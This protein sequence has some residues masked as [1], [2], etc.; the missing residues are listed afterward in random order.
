MSRQAAELAQ[1]L[2]RH[3]EPVCRHYLSNG[4][5]HGRYWIVGD[6][7]NTPG[8]SLYVRLAGPSYGPGAAGKWTDSAS[9]EYG[10]LIDLIAGNCGL[11]SFRDACREARRFLS[12]PPDL[13]GTVRDPPAPRNSPEAARRLFRMGVPIIGTPAEAYLRARGISGGL[14]WPSLRFHPALWYRPDADAPR[15]SWPGLL[16]AGTDPDGRITGLHRTFI[17]RARPDKAPLADPRRALGHLLG[18]GVRFGPAEPAPLRE[19]RS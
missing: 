4:R 3:A 8:R 16:A 14:D 19:R 5:R 2:A 13:P 6:V 7:R 10:D 18:N 9:G 12:L 11:A 15:D 17:D 1:H